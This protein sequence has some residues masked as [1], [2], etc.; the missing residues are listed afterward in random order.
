MKNSLGIAFAVTVLLGYSATAMQARGGAHGSGHGG[1]HG[2]GHSDGHHSGSGHHS[3]HHEEHGNH[4]G[5]H[6]TANHHQD[7]NHHHADV[8][9]HY[10]PHNQPFTASWRNNHPNG[11]NGGYGG[12][13][14]GTGLWAGT[15]FGAAA[16]WLGMSGANA[17]AYG[18]PAGATT[19]Y[20]ADNGAVQTGQ[21]AD[22]ASTPSGAQLAGTEAG[23][24]PATKTQLAEAT[25]LAES[26]KAEPP[27]DAQFM[28]L[29][30]YSL[31]AAESARCQAPWS[32]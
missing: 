18:Y 25:R 20:T 28:S 22:S 10:H 19:A 6:D 26:G 29:G 30:V 31:A 15:G 4:A 24:I 9:A 14:L 8:N 7:T 3:G 11:W 2:A 32:S 21:L 1:G 12:Y 23:D 5:H 16:T 17:L 27:K 13:G